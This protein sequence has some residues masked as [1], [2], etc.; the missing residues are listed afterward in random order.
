MGIVELGEGEETGFIDF[1][2][3]DKIQEWVQNLHEIQK[4]DI[5]V[6]NRDKR[7][8][9]DVIQTNVGQIFAHDAGEVAATITDGRPRAFVEKSRDYPHGIERLVVPLT[10]NEGQTAGTLIFDYTSICQ[11]LTAE[12][13]REAVG[14][15]TVGILMLSLVTGMGLLLIRAVTS[16]ILRLGEAARRLGTGD[17]DAEIPASGAGEI[18]DLTRAFEEMRRGLR[19]SIRERDEEI[20]RRALLEE[21]LRASALR[22]RAI[23]QTMPLTVLIMDPSG[24]VKL[25]NRAAEKTF[26]WRE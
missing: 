16:P 7:I 22:Q 21:S 6:T 4:R 25:W 20:E 12:T 14:Y 18:G 19:Q 24:I 2:H 15:A 3:I 9:A 13:R 17:L 10:S 8:V 11:E 5:V 23:I 26:G 1:H